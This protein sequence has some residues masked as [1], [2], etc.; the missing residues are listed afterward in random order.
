MSRKIYK[1]LFG[2]CLLFSVVTAQVTHPNRFVTKQ[3]LWVFA[4]ALIVVL[5]LYAIH[6]YSSN[7]RLYKD[8]DRLNKIGND[9]QTKVKTKEQRAQTAENTL[10]MISDNTFDAIAILDGFD[11]IIYWNT[12]AEKLFGYSQ[13]SILKCDLVD[14]IIPKDDAEQFRHKYNFNRGDDLKQNEKVIK[15][16]AMKENQ[17]QF[18]A[19]MKMFNMKYEG[20]FNTMCII[21]ESIES[22]ESAIIQELKKE[23]ID[24]QKIYKH[25]LEKNQGKVIDPQILN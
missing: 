11:R 6:L 17:T 23:I 13:N 20:I 25:K 2:N 8:K 1:I 21:R 7:K 18:S 14:K 3:T 19:E 10:K 12:A 24:K 9:L 4:V 22:S 15:F 16:K 5:F